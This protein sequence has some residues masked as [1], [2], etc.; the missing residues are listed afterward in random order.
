MFYSYFSLKILYYEAW[1]ITIF[2]SNEINHWLKI[3]VLFQYFS[4]RY[5]FFLSTTGTLVKCFYFNNMDSFTREPPVEKDLLC[6]K[7]VRAVYCTELFEKEMVWRS[8]GR[9]LESPYFWFIKTV[10][11]SATSHQEESWVGFLTVQPLQLQYWADLKLF[12][13]DQCI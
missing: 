1:C 10:P 7:E 2:T 8:K 11:P 5:A 3:E 4:Q 6:C 13:E 12:C 9:R